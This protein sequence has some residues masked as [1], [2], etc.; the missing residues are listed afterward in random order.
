MNWIKIDK[1]IET[2]YDFEIIGYNTDWIDEDFNP[3]GTRAC[4]QNDSGEKGWCSAKWNNSHDCY[5][6]DFDTAPT[7]I[8]MIPKTPN[9]Q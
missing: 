8:M 3:E 2:N 9:K 4:F 6:A 5:D 1:S 7:H